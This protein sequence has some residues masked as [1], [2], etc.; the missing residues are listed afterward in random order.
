[1]DKLR[2]RQLGVK[3]AR[4]VLRIYR[5]ISTWNRSLMDLYKEGGEFEKHLI[6]TRKPCSNP[7][8]CGNPR[9]L[10]EK[11]RNEILAIYNEIDGV[12]EIK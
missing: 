3:R 8:C 6:H 2:R 9:K 12:N 11:A 5:S 1:M 10:G 4:R 7:Y